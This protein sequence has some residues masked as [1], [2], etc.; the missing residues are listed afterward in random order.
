VRRVWVAGLVVSAAL[1]SASTS[2]AQG[3]AHSAPT[4][5]RSALM[6]NTGVALARDGAAPFVNP[7]TIIRIEDQNLAFSVNFYTLSLNHFSDWHQPGSVDARFGDVA[8]SGTSVVASHL[9][10]L[11]STLCLFFTL[12]GVVGEDA[13]QDDDAP[14]WRRGRQ[15]LALCLG[16]LE[17][18]DTTLPALA[19]RGPTAAGTTAQAQSIRRSWNRLHAGPTFSNQVT[20]ELAIGLSLHG[21]YTAES[22]IV[23]AS[24]LTSATAGPIQSTFGSSGDGHSIDL[25]AILGATYRLGRFTLGASIELP[26]LHLTG[27]YDATTHSDYAGAGTGATLSSGSGTFAAPPPLRIGVG[28]GAEWKR[29]V[30]E[31]DESYVAPQSDALKTSVH[32]DQNDVINGTLSSTAFD[33][34]FATRGTAA[35]NTAAGAEYFVSPSFSLIGGVSTNFSATPALSPTMSV[36]NLAQERMHHVMLSFGIGSY[37]ESGDLLLGVQTGYGW[38]QAL[39]VNPYVLPNDWAIVD[40]Q[41]YSALFVLAGATNLRALRRAVERVEHVVTTGKPEEAKPPETVK[42]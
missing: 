18:E 25:A 15:K 20:D 31:L 32:V 19:F 4:G 14:R 11:P 22:F 8:L 30:F 37:G 9:A 39:A 13:V 28:L 34:T 12:A 10:A 1:V 40:T 17:S 23:D 42:P 24:S 3:N 6:G 33:A 27:S 2:R 7:A 5:G 29:W 36:G 16:S 38:G 41:S 21:V 35:F 26:A